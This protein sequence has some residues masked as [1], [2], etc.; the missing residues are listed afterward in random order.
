MAPTLSQQLVQMPNTIATVDRG[1]H[2]LF[3]L[4]APRIV[5]FGNLLSADEC[6]QMIEMSRGKLARSSVVNN[7]TGAYDIHPHRTSDGTYFYRGE[8]DLIRRIEQR[9]ADLVQYPEENGEPIQILH[10]QPG[11]E[12]KPHYDYFDPRQPGNEQVLTQGGQRIATLVMYLND[13]E[14]GGS[15]VFPEVGIDVLPRRGN[16]VYFAYCSETGA[17]DSRSLHGGSPVGGGEKWIA[18]KWFRER[19]YVGSGA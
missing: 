5:L 1:V 11:G 3:A 13:V 8:N 9:I 15:T 17:L 18:T 2:M 14:T 10:Y 19:Q 16:A 7:E 12:Y 4:T 6:E